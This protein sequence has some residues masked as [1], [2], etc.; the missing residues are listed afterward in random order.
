MISFNLRRAVLAVSG[1]LFNNRSGGIVGE[2]E[3][4]R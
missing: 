2:V 4:Q 3:G 1:A